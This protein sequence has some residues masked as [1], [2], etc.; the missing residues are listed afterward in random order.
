MKRK[1]RVDLKRPQTEFEAVIADWE[2]GEADSADAIHHHFTKLEPTM[3]DWIDVAEEGRRLWRI[4]FG[5]RLDE[6][7]PELAIINGVAAS[8]FALAFQQVAKALGVT[9]YG[10]EQASAVDAAISPEEF[11]ASAKRAEQ[12]LREFRQKLR[13]RE[14]ATP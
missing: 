10:V 9:E 6:Y 3:D 8:A 14:P 11:V 1:K 5:E 4:S 2:S 13:N 12:E 7:S